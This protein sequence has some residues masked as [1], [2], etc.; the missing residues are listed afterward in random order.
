[1]IGGSADQSGDTARLRGSRK[2]Y[3]SGGA[4][5]ATSGDFR[6]WYSPLRNQSFSVLDLPPCV[7]PRPEPARRGTQKIP[8]LSV[9]VSLRVGQTGE[10]TSDPGGQKEWRP[11][12]L[13][14]ASEHQPVA[15]WHRSLSDRHVQVG[16]LTS[17]RE[18][19]LP[20]IPLHA[21]GSLEGRL[22]LFSAFN[23]YIGHLP[24]AF[25]PNA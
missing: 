21:P 8:L 25:F 19:D 14:D 23:E 18:F 2:G 4:R 5:A 7:D 24:G 6:G 1:V 10:S 16:N 20:F 13:P 22:K 17:Q 15:P 11:I 9:Q 12:T 3:L